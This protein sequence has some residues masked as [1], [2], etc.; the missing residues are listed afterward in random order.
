M[1]TIIIIIIIIIDPNI[2]GHVIATSKF[3]AGAL[4][5]FSLCCHS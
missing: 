5:N 3:L 4:R 2:I 1:I